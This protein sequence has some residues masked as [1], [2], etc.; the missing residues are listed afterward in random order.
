MAEQLAIFIELREKLSKDY[1]L[2]K[3]TD[4]PWKACGKYL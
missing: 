2:I 1:S 3:V 4:V